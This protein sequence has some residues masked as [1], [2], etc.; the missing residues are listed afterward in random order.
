MP[1]ETQRTTKPKYP[2]AD[3]LFTLQYRV[4]G[5]LLTLHAFDTN[6]TVSRVGTDQTHYVVHVRAVYAGEPLG[7]FTMNCPTTYPLDGTRTRRAVSSILTHAEW[8]DDPSEAAAREW[9]AQHGEELSMLVE[10]RLGL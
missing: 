1:P 3:R 8:L 9:A 7:E 2:R 5:K 6:K 4:A 10:E